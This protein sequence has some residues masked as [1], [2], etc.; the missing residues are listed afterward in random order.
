MLDDHHALGKNLVLCSLRIAGL[1]VRD[2]GTLSARDI[3]DIVRDEN[4]ELLLI[5]TLML[6]SALRVKDLVSY[7]QADDIQTRVYVGGAPFRLDPE[8]W[9]K[10]NAHGMGENSTEAVALVRAWM[11]EHHE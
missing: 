2:L 8:L 3:A 6:R 5:S 10:V 7:L 1:P 9:K 11:D 4:I